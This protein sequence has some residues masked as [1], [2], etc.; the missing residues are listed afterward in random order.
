MKSEESLPR[1]V[2]QSAYRP[3]RSY[4]FL[5]PPTP[6]LPPLSLSLYH[7]STQRD[8]TTAASGREMHAPFQA[9]LALF[10]FMPVA[11]PGL[12]LLGHCHP[13]CLEREWHQFRGHARRSMS[14][15]GV[16]HVS[17]QHYY[18][19]IEEGRMIARSYRALFW[20][21]THAL[22]AHDWNIATGEKCLHCLQQF[23]KR[24]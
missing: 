20:T 4:S 24:S 5:P 15:A 21:H 9:A 12:I 3:L 11:V 16:G 23:A 22:H 14:D 13:V 8:T 6:L 10:V 2:Q 7:I 1:N 18:R 17:S 19:D